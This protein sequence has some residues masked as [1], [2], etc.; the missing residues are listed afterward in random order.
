MKDKNVTD[1]CTVNSADDDLITIVDSKT[2]Q[3][4]LLRDDF[5]E[6]MG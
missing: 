5:H 3:S 1:D 6:G 4:I 2:S